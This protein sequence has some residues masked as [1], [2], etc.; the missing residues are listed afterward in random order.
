[1][2]QKSILLGLVMGLT[3]ASQDT[4]SLG[5]GKIQVHSAL[6]QPLQASIDLMMGDSEDLTNLTVQ[7]A[8]AADYKKVGLDRSF[9]PNNISVALDE[10]NP[11]VINVT[12]AGPVSEPIVTLL[13][14]VNWGNGRIFREFTILLDPPVY[15][16]SQITSTAPVAE[17]TY[18]TPEPIENQPEVVTEA[19]EVPV[20]QTRAEAEVA[21]DSERNEEVVESTV[22]AAPSYQ[23]SASEVEVMSGDTLWSIANQNKPSSLSTNQM[24][25]ALFNH[26]PQAFSNNNINQL[27]KGSRLMIPTANELQSISQAE[28][29]DL[30]QSHNDS[31][32]PVQR[33]ADSYSSFQTTEPAY[34]APAE[35]S[36]DSI[37][38]GVEL[39]GST[40]QEDSNGGQEGD[41]YESLNETAVAEELYNKDSENAELKERLSELEGIVEQQQAALEIKSDDLANLED[42]LA[43]P[44]DETTDAIQEA[45]ETDDVWGDDASVASINEEAAVEDDSMVEEDAP[46][47]TDVSIEEPADNADDAAANEAPA[48]EKKQTPSF[49]GSQQQEESMVDKGVNWVMDNL[50]WLALGLLGLLVLIFV[51]KFFRSRDKDVAEETSFLDDI[52]TRNKD[53]E[54]SAAVM[55]EDTKV[56]DP[57]EEEVTESIDVDDDVLADL[58][59]KIDFES[60]DDDDDDIFK[61][62]DDE[63]EVEASTDS[64]ADDEGEA[65]DDGFDLDGFLNDDE[66]D[67]SEASQEEQQT[68]EQLVDTSD[69]TEDD[70]D[71]D[72]SELDDL[73]ESSET[74]AEDL[75]DEIDDALESLSD[76]AEDT[77]EKIE[78]TVEAAEETDFSLDEDFEFDLDGEMEDLVEDAE[79]AV[80]DISE[81]AEEAFDEVLDIADETS[82]SLE[83]DT[84]VADD[85]IDL[86]LDLD[87]MLE[88]GDVIDTK[89]DLAKAYLEM[90]DHDGAKNL[91][92]EVSAEGNDSQIEEAKKLLDDM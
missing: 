76:D 90:G 62:F 58:D 19:A 21:A 51:P 56:N 14:D 91:L 36:D 2:K 54:E 74:A 79:D 64:S 82:E 61:G 88:D 49:S 13:L 89:L 44:A 59:K 46:V 16:S 43:E 3:L 25:A 26:N 12:S 73:E 10:N 81:D 4:Q 32:A 31:W 6:D 78:E 85:D 33:V 40:D 50:Q 68:D 39:A 18:Q 41:G 5:M 86:G 22:E 42:Q 60:E 55:T 57:L 17:S 65:S 83:V 9:V 1:M 71:F 28:A 92:K 63:P 27:I 47:I 80:E 87:D 84:E 69:D 34:E 52:K 75:S 37:D 72:L 77:V 53:S 30:V 24:M 23:A 66:D 20:V 35:T 70:F 67:D 38:Y 11:L 7:L 48:Q 29:L 8:S 15:S 45:V